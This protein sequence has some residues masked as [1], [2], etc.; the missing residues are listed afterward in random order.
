MGLYTNLCKRISKRQQF[1]TILELSFLLAVQFW[2]SEQEIIGSLEPHHSI[3]SLKQC[4][5]MFKQPICCTLGLQLNHTQQMEMDTTI[6]QVNL[7]K[8]A[9]FGCPLCT[10]LTHHLL[11]YGFI[12]TTDS[13]IRLMEYGIQL[14]I[15]DT[16]LIASLMYRTIIEFTLHSTMNN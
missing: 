12:L 1:M 7:L 8:L 2:C 14:I 6:F 10:R 16:S 3:F 11:L 9:F 15:K 13:Q 4:H 5:T